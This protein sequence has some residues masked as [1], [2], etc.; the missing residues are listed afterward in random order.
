M[1]KEGNEFLF[2]KSKEGYIRLFIL[3]FLYVPL[4]KEFII[5]HIKAPADMLRIRNEKVDKE[6]A[7]RLRSIKKKLYL[8]ETVKDGT[9]YSMEDLKDGR[10]FQINASGLEYSAVT[11]L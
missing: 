3:I 8:Y 11:F 7:S 5:D 4:L 2:L 9:C 6:E 1:I 10:N